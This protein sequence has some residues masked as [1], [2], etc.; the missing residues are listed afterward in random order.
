MRN[1][2]KN[3]TKQKAWGTVIA[4][5]RLG[6][7]PGRVNP[8]IFSQFVISKIL[9]IRHTWLEMNCHKK[10]FPSKNKFL[11]TFIVTVYFFQKKPD[12]LRRRQVP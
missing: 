2:Q 6:S 10:F 5:M 11:L 9:G 8:L 12:P 4:A 7:G 1:G 3:C